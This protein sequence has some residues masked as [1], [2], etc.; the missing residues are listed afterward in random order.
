VARPDGDRELASLALVVSEFAAPSGVGF[1]QDIQS[2]LGALSRQDVSHLDRQTK[3][4]LARLINLQI[5]MQKA[6]ML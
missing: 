2:A 4:A 6:G 5:F 1:A 3:M